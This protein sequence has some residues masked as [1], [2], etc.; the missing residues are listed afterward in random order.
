MVEEVTTIETTTTTVTIETTTTTATIETTTT[1]TVT[2][3]VMKET[4]HTEVTL[5][6]T[7]RALIMTADQVTNTTLSIHKCCATDHRK[8]DL[9]DNLSLLLRWE[10]LRWGVLGDRMTQ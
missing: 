10:V 8:E 2:I 3:G 6:V 9:V 1:T 5:T 7:A 4:T